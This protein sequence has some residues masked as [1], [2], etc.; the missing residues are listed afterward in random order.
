MG[1]VIAQTQMSISVAKKPLPR[2]PWGNPDLQGFWNNAP[3]VA[4]PFERPTA[5]GTRMYLNDEEYARRLE[6]IR[7][8]NELEVED[9]TY[10]DVIRV[11][12]SR[13]TSQ[14]FEPPDGRIPPYT[15][16]AMLKLAG[17]IEQ[18]RTNNEQHPDTT[19]AWGVGE[20]CISRTLPGA[21]ATR[22]YNNNRQILQTSQYVVM[23]YEM[24]HDARIIPLNRNFH[25]SSRIRSWMGY[26]RGRW[27]GNTLVVD[28]TNFRERI[29]YN[30][31]PG[32][33]NEPPAGEHARITERFTLMDGDTIEYTATVDDPET[34]TRQWSFGFTMK[35]DTTQ[36]QILEYACHEGN[37][38]TITIGLG[39]A[40]TEDAKDS[41][42]KK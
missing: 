31:R 18:E 30:G 19:A 33:A 17:R 21:S 28:V 4:T 36:T 34:F 26:S 14:V 39:G 11:P 5:M 16:Q 9:L 15:S 3:D 38:N 10:Y 12:P 27:E 2:T 8:H 32:N 35:K 37:Y 23:F 1:T 20:R 7:K 13:R 25:V 40:R 24:I 42:N 6:E 22:A 29:S 41:H